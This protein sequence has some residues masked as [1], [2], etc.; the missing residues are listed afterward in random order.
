MQLVKQCLHNVPNLRPRTEEL[1]TRL[2]GMRVQVEG[3]YGSSHP[4]RLDMVRVRLAKVVKEKDSRIEELTQQQV[5][6]KRQL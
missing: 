4:I 1:L 5:L 3:E 6:Y 2:Q